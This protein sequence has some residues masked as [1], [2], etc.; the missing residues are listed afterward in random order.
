[1][2]SAAIEVTGV[3]RVWVDAAKNGASVAYALPA[4]C[5]LRRSYDGQEWADVASASP[6]T[7]TGGEASYAIDCVTYTAPVTATLEIG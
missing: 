1:M 5:L 2:S 4:G 7:H 6:F 3:G